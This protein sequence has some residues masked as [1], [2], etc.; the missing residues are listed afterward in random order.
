[1][2]NKQKQKKEINRYASIS[3][4]FKYCSVSII[5][6]IIID[7]TLR[8]TQ[9]WVLNDPLELNPI[10]IFNEKNEYI[11]YR[12]NDIILPSINDWFK[13]QLIESQINDYGIL[14]LTKNPI[15]FTMW[16]NYGSGH[17][18]FLLEFKQDFNLHEVFKSL[19]NEVYPIKKVNYVEQY[20]INIPEISND[21]GQFSIKNFNEKY[22]YDKTKRWEYEKEYRLVRNLKDLNKPVRTKGSYRELEKVYK[23]N[24]PF[25]V[26]D[27]ITFGA[28]MSLE[29]KKMIIENLKDY[30]INYFQAFIYKDEYDEFGDAGRVEL[31]HIQN[32]NILKTIYEI[33]PQ[34]CSIE[35]Q[36]YKNRTIVDIK[37]IKELPYY[38]HYG[39]LVEE[40][41]TN[42]L[43]RKKSRY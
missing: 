7:K 39:K 16:N 20:V 26:I 30:K 37:S 27:S 40:M 24:L 6:K 2:N 33:L 18:G 15:S 22:F 5:D 14:S 34:S 29:N 21:N 12:I 32:H 10:L 31:L 35:R 8:F 4:Y 23:I 13:I 11:K 42:M 1:M 25:E 38:Q 28:H 43:K 36:E 19:N 9:P 3:S 17:K 41:Y